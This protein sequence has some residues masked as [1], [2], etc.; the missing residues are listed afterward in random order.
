MIEKGLSSEIT[1]CDRWAIKAD[2][3]IAIGYNKARDWAFDLSVALGYHFNL[4]NCSLRLTPLVG[5][6]ID[7][8]RYHLCD[9]DFCQISR[10]KQLMT[11][12]SL[13]SPHSIERTGIVP[14]SDLISITPLMNVGNS[15][16]TLPIIL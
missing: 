14:S 8:E 10:L 16:P 15:I 3:N 9:R 13:S 2:G 6:A 5:Y 11:S 12:Q 7:Q 1:L 4:C